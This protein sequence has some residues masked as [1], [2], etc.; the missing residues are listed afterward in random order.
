MIARQKFNKGDRVYFVNPDPGK[1]MFATNQTGTVV[2]FGRGPGRNAALVRVAVDGRKTPVTMHMDFW[3][4]GPGGSDVE[5]L[6]AAVRRYVETRGGKLIVIGGVSVMR[7][8]GEPDEAFYL[9][10][11]CLGRKPE[12]TPE[13][14]P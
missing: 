2:G 10:V 8:P 3:T 7:L 1:G 5:E 6:Y 13:S 9:A 14:Q 12:K 11:K 4:L